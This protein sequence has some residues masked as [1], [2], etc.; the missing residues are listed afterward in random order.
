MQLGRAIVLEPL[1][2]YLVL[3]QKI[4]NKTLKKNLI[5]SWNFGPKIKQKK[6]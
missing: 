1:S 2:G 4:L 3:G 5:P 6:E